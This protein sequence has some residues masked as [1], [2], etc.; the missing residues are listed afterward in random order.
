MT[1]GTWHVL[2]SETQ[3]DS[4]QRQKNFPKISR[5]KFLHFLKTLLKPW[6]PVIRAGNKVG[7]LSDFRLGA[8]V[9]HDQNCG[10][11]S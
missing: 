8:S 5:K 6:Q 10:A 1:H 9:P 11:R 7:C 3:L 4:G 2:L